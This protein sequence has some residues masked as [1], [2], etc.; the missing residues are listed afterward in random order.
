MNCVDIS[1]AS[2][3]LLLVNNGHNLILTNIYGDVLHSVNVSHL[4]TSNMY[5]MVYICKGF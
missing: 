2:S 5:E 4:C 1:F 3:I